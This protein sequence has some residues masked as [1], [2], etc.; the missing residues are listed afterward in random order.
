M[1]LMS[2]IIIGIILSLLVVFIYLFKFD[3]HYNEKEIRFGMSAPFSGTLHSIG[4]ELF[5]GAN[6]Y[7][8]YINENGGVNGRVF[9]IIKK[10]DKYEPKITAENTLEL[11]KKYKVFA[12]LGFVGTPTSKV[13]LPIAI[14]YNI[15]YIG[16]FSG[17]DFLR[18]VPRNPLV[19]NG[20]TSYKKEIEKLIEYFVDKKQF[21]K[22][23]VF[24]QNDSYG[25]SG[26]KGVKEALKRRG[27]KLCAEG[28]YKRNTLSVGH[29][30]YEIAHKRPEVV[31][32]IGAT[33]PTAEFIK[34]ARKNKNTEDLH[35]GVISFV[36]S[37]IFL[38]ELNFEAKNII[39]SQ[40]MPS[41]WGSLSKEVVLYREIMDKYYLSK[42]YSYV[43][44]EGYFIAKMTI[45][46]FKRLGKKFTKEDFLK[47]MEKMYLEMESSKDSKESKI[48]KCLNNVYLTYYEDGIF[49]E[50]DEEDN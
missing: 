43:S 31:I 38:K 5:R 10:D 44:L 42:D 7:I 39:I 13:A 36:G 34:R 8:R 40:V 19:L 45:E 27:I 2:K 25:R 12:L 24:Y 33:K 30:L 26:L 9:R 15:P 11:I 1:S 3:S 48:C 29:A 35:Y 47:E 18:K 41:P 22:I 32:M 4:E 16:A 37:S 20:R 14:K 21:S 50:I 6:S 46:L 23:A 28:S 49:W 17:A